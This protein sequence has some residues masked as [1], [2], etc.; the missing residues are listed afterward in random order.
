MRC[1]PS[2]VS[3][4]FRA[5]KR[6]DEGHLSGPALADGLSVWKR[7][8]SDVALSSGLN[9]PVTTWPCTRWGLPCRRPHSRRGAL[10]P[11]LFT[12]TPRQARGGIFSVALS[13]PRTSAGRWVLPT[14]VVQW[15]SDF[16]PLVPGYKERPSTHPATVY[17]TPIPPGRPCFFN[18]QVPKLV[19]LIKKRC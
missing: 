3:R 11:H 17:Y 18:T 8:T 10:L 15:C 1:K 2:S 14:T 16:P 7:P 19:P 12:L 6:R 5:R 4:R 9:R 13:L